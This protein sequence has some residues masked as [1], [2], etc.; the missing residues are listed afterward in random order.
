[1]NLFRIDTRPG[2]GRRLT[3]AARYREILGR[4]IVRF[5]IVNLL[6]IL[7]FLP[8]TA[9]VLL[10]ILSSSILILIPVCIIGGMI[11]GPA[12]ACMHDTILRSLRDAPGKP[13]ENYKRALKQNWRQA[14]V[15]GIVFSLMLGFYAFMMMLIWWAEIFPGWGTI[16]LLFFGMLLFF[17]FFTV[18]WQL[19]VLFD[20]PQKQRIGNCLLFII[21]SFRK[22]FYASVL[23]II[24]WAV[25]ILFMPLSVIL[26][27]FTGI[28]YI[29]FTADFKLYDT[30]NEIFEI[31]KQIIEAFP[32]QEA[33]YEDD[34]AWLKRKQEEMRNPQK[35]SVSAT[36]NN[37]RKITEG[38]E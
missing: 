22:V 36:E 16:A 29:L 2:T 5:L 38:T 35:A 37:D 25:L 19:L 11:A 34:E 18:Y 20:Q 33:V 14:L 26:L 12:I 27:P 4:D 7:G 32:E 15:P 23:Q 10:A 31:E 9:G 17:M 28:W 8:L 6:T 1:M 24:Y 30:M 21:R 13:A 3:G